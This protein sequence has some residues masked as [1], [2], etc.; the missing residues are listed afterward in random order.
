M[1]DEL[2]NLALSADS[3][4]MFAEDLFVFRLLIYI[5]HIRGIMRYINLRLTYLL[6]ISRIQQLRRRSA[7]VAMTSAMRQCPHSRPILL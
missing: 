7:W 2:R 1:S 3:L 5:Q 6:S 4:F